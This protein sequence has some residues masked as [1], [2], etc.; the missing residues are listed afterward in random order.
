MRGPH[1]AAA[2]LLL[3]AALTA[4]GGDYEP[5]EPPRA[6]A[7]ETIPEGSV[8]LAVGDSLRF[9]ASFPQAGI[10]LTLVL[11]SRD[12]AVAAVRQEAG[13]EGLGGAYGWIR[14]RGPGVTHAVV[15]PVEAPMHADSLRVRVIIP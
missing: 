10:P 13:G 4:C 14:A 12:S 5:V 11:S 6:P 1:R 9:Y 15:T 3:A 8:E 7:L 2:R